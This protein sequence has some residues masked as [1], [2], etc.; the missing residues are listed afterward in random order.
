M[1]RRLRQGGKGGRRSG[2]ILFTGTVRVALCSLLV[3][4]LCSRTIAQTGEE[5]DPDRKARMDQAAVDTLKKM[6]RELESESPFDSVPRLESF[7]KMYADTEIVMDEQRQRKLIQRLRLRRLAEHGDTLA[8]LLAGL[9]YERSL[10][11]DNCKGEGKSQCDMCEGT[12]GEACYRCNGTGKEECDSC[13][14]EGVRTCR[15]CWGDG[16]VY[17]RITI[18]TLEGR[19]W[20]YRNVRCD[21]CKGKGK[22][23]C[24]MCKGKATQVCDRCDGKKFILAWNCDRCGG[25]GTLACRSC[26]GSGRAEGL[27]GKP[28]RSAPPRRSGPMTLAE[29]EAAFSMIE[30]NVEAWWKLKADED[31]LKEGEFDEQRRELFYEE[32]SPEEQ[33]KLLDKYG[34]LKR[35]WSEEVLS[36]SEFL[37]K[38]RALLPR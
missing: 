26:R 17:K 28:T 2:G 35:A 29:L 33:V 13:Y 15:Q 34:A 30:E 37:T 9:V 22:V 8:E 32:L 5:D 12:G 19:D 1:L 10:L 25:A 36:K 20:E 7:L 38:C 3:L 11:C 6:L 23:K 31:T 16:M 27:S 24:D 18:H 14:G 4:S 21:G